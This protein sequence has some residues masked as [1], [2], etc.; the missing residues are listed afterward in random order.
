MPAFLISLL[1]WFAAGLASRML[2]ATGLGIFT[3]KAIDT[4]FKNFQNMLIQ[5]TNQ[6]PAEILSLCSLLGL[7]YYLSVV[8]GAMSA[9]T[10]IYV[11]KV[12]IGKG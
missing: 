3:Y 4:A 1:T 5:Q 6:L 8:L 12:F 9:A 11:S 2:I 10:F 7:D